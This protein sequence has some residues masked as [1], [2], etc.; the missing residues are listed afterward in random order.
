M[1]T[2]RKIGAKHVLYSIAHFEE[3]KYMFLI[4]PYCNAGDLEKYMDKEKIIS[5][6]EARNF[7]S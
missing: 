5:E 3:D 4:L 6:S 7:I 1:E 2:L